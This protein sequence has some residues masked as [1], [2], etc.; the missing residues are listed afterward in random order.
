MNIDKRLLAYKPISI[1]LNFDWENTTYDERVLARHNYIEEQKKKD[2]NYIAWDFPE[3]F[4]S[5]YGSGT[6]LSDQYFQ[7]FTRLVSTVGQILKIHNDAFEISFGL[8]RKSGYMRAKLKRGGNRLDVAVHRV[9]GSTFIPIPQE[10]KDLRFKLVVN[11]KND[12]KTC[13][14]RSN[15]E[16]CAQENNVHAA[17]KTGVTE[18]SCYKMIVELPGPL[19]KKTYY[20]Y[21]MGDIEKIGLMQASVSLSVI[22]KR[23]YLH[24]NWLKVHKSELEGKNIGIPPDELLILKDPKYGYTGTKAL[25]GT[26]VSEGPCKGD[27]FCF[28]GSSELQRNGFLSTSAWRV[29]RHRKGT[30]RGCYFTAMTRE[31]AADIPIGLTEAQKEHIFGKCK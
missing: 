23:Q 9:V 27:K 2:P 31:E 5:H 17:L 26:I 13:N 11:H 24:S 12:I 21:R 16:W 19:Y 4:K 30:H 1:T 6:N 18:V 22:N 29:I 20:F 25:V 14:I 28:F 8:K 10:L 3:W 7:D 15:L